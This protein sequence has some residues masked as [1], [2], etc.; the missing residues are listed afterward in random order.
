MH[1]NPIALVRINIYI[2]MYIFISYYIY[3]IGRVE[4][5]NYTYNIIQGDDVVDS[6][7]GWEKC[8]NGNSLIY[9]LYI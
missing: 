8:V 9:E 2:Y 1:L 6:L 4:D 7:K 3:L 5:N